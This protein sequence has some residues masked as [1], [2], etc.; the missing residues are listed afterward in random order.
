MR[1]S[2]LPACLV[3]TLSIVARADDPADPT[4][5]V[6]TPIYPSDVSFAMVPRRH[7][8]EPDYKV[9][10]EAHGIAYRLTGDGEMKVIYRTEG[11]YSFEVFI[12]MDGRLLVQMGPWNSGQE[13]SKTDL[14]V[15]FHKDG[16]LIKSYS[17]AELI[18]DPEKIE[19]SAS[20]YRWRAPSPFSSDLT[21]AQ[22]AALSPHL[23]YEK[24]FTLNTIDGWTY[25]FDATTGQIKS[26]KRTGG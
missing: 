7:G 14:A 20:H 3:F 26:T 17:T 8:P 22:K 15:A 9:V 16:K 11:W 13:V 4:P 19:R 2:L 24:E 18:K 12:S 1:Y 6:F 5:L 23:S 10:Q 25:V 21:E